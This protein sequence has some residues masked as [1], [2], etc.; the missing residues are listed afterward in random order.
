MIHIIMNDLRFQRTRIFNGSAVFNLPKKNTEF[1]SFLSVN[2]RTHSAE[3]I[4]Q[5]QTVLTVH[6]PL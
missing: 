5:D 2:G 4:H 3:I 6:F 1:K